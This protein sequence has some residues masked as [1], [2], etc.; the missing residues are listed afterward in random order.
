MILNLSIFAVM[1]LTYSPYL[2]G[3]FLTLDA[4]W[5]ILGSSVTRE[6]LLPLEIFVKILFDKIALLWELLGRFPPEKIRIKVI[7]RK[8]ISKM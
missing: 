3:G 1:G 4:L 6:K 2:S 8:I 7:N 5:T